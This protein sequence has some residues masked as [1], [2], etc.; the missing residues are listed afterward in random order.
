MSHQTCQI[1]NDV[2]DQFKVRKD[3]SNAALILKIDVNELL[4][5]VDS[6]LEGINM[7]EL[8]EELPDSTPRFVVISFELKHKDG[9]IS[10]PLTGIYYHPEGSSLNNK[11]LYAS[12]SA[13]TFHE[14]GIVGKLIDAEE[15]NDDWLIEKL[16]SSK[17]RP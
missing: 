14:A 4:V 11:M 12:S 10:Y 15:L 16:E 5:V 17:T 7:S 1:S 3:K 2:K 13:V 8:S 6:Y 9:R